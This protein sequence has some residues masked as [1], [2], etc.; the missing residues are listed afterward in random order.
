VSVSAL[1]AG[2]PTSLDSLRDVVIPPHHRV[3][4]RINDHNAGVDRALLVEANGAVVVERDEYPA[5]G[6]GIDAALGVP[7][8]R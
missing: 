8:D 7:I 6:T 2:N 1:V 4:A 5:K 3:A